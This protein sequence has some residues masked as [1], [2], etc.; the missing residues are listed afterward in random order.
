MDEFEFKDEAP[1]I[2][3]KSRSVKRAAAPGVSTIAIVAL[4]FGVGAAALFPMGILG[5]ISM[6]VAAV[7]AVLSFVA[8]RRNLLIGLLAMLINLGVVVYVLW[9]QYGYFDAIMR[10]IMKLAG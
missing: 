10:P 4:C 8:I 2:G 3:S 1:I 5:W 7:G 9:L 6:P